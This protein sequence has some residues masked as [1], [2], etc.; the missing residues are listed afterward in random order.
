[1][2]GAVGSLALKRGIIFPFFQISGNVCERSEALKIFVKLDAIVGA[3]SFNI[4]ALI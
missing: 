3:E 4:L 1:L 2:L